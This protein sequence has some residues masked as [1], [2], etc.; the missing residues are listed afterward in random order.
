MHENLKR[1]PSDLSDL[2]AL[3]IQR[4]RDHGLPSYNVFRKICGLKVAKVFQ[5][6][7]KEIDDYASVEK[8]RLLYKHPDDVDLFLGGLLERPVA[9]GA[10]GPTFSCIVAEQFRTL[11]FGDRFW[12]ERADPVVGF[13]AE[14][15]KELKEVSLA[16]VICDNSDDI[17][18]MPMHALSVNSPV[19]SC[20]KISSVN[21]EKWREYPSV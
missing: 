15:L 8:L 5:D 13:T 9:N 1:G 4:G 12:Y 21:L 20:D 18:E 2:A 17:K 16:R 14:Q 7:G 6:F 11:R 3:N 10:L 19:V